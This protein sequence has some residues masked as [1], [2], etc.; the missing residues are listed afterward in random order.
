MIHLLVSQTETREN[1]RTNIQQLRD[2]YARRSSN[3]RGKNKKKQSVTNVLPVKR[4]TLMNPSTFF[5]RLRYYD[6]NNNNTIIVTSLAARGE[7]N[8]TNTRPNIIRIMYAKPSRDLR[9]I[10]IRDERDIWEAAKR[11]KIASSPPRPRLVPPFRRI[12][13]KWYNNKRTHT[14]QSRPIRCDTVARARA[15]AVCV[16]A[17]RGGGRT[18]I[19]RTRE[20]SPERKP[21]ARPVRA[22]SSRACVRV[23]DIHILQT[24][25]L[26]KTSEYYSFHTSAS[27]LSNL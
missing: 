11:A 23:D 8:S 21:Y 12:R 25:V 2:G 3:W 24:R 20:L 1:V 26:P 4:P 18:R 22:W 17:K 7:R 5:A 19:I 16:M 10:V 14:G 15:R 9:H 27:V 6:N 13:W